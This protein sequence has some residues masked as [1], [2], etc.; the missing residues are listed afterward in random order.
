MVS[1]SATMISHWYI[2]VPVW[3]IVAV[4]CWALVR[5]MRGR[6]WPRWAVLLGGLAS[7]LAAGCA[8]MAVVGQMLEALFPSDFDGQA[9]LDDAGGAGIV[10]LPTVAVA[11]VGDA[12][13]HLDETIWSGF[14]AIFA[15]LAGAER[16]Q[17]NS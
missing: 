11:A 5:V 6:G 14:L 12:L 1:P 13:R 2:H 3:A 9:V 17:Q 7:C 16:R 15:G 8:T 4:L 10:L